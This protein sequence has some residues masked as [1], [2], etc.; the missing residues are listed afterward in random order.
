MMVG[1]L[2]I[3]QNFFNRMPRLGVCNPRGH[4]LLKDSTHLPKNFQHAQAHHT[5]KVILLY[6][7]SYYNVF[8]LIFFFHLGI[9]CKCWCRHTLRYF[10][11]EGPIIVVPN[12][13]HIPNFWIRRAWNET[14]SYTG[15]HPLTHKLKESYYFALWK[16][17]E[18]IYVD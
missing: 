10:H 7:W 6:K 15:K 2:G 5:H 9:S 17:S 8:P 13:H 3:I 16:A 11:E 18:W 4:V 14:N 1:H 12:Y